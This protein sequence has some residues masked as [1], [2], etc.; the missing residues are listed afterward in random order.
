[1]RVLAEELRTKLDAFYELIPDA[2]IEGAPLHVYG[3]SWTMQNSPHTT[4]GTGEYHVRLAK[5]LRLGN[6]AQNGLSGAFLIDMVAAVQAPSYAGRDRRFTPGSRG[7]VTLQCLV[8]DLAGPNATPSDPLSLEFYKTSLRT[9]LAAVSAGTFKDADA[10]SYTGSWGSTVAAVAD[11]YPAGKL[12]Y[13]SSVG[14]TASWT[15][16][17]DEVWVNTSG[18]R[19]GV[20]A[21][22]WTASVNGVPLMT[23]SP[24]GVIP[25]GLNSPPHGPWVDAPL[26]VKVTGMNGAAGT[27]GAKTLTITVNQ[28]QNTFLAGVFTPSPRPPRVFVALEAP[29]NPVAAGVSAWNEWEPAYRQ[30]IIDVVAEFP[31]ASTV[32]LAPDWNNPDYIRTTDPQKAHP[33]D[34]G[35]A[36]IASRFEAAIRS[37]ITE[38][39]PGVIAL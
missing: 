36:H 1:M 6:V 8:N 14:S 25:A 15:V 29:R 38:P 21:R 2:N 19:P 34:L 16:T 27:T 22:S 24:V 5:R 13:S 18:A 20:T 26:A 28:P 30:A 17:G 11:Y 10:A 3:H 9:F 7:I 4:T 35:M 12:K 33:N 31:N 23:F 39:D 32:D 37:T